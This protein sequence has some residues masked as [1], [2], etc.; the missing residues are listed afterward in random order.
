MA[1]EELNAAE[2]FTPEANEETIKV[3]LNLEVDNHDREVGREYLIDGEPPRWAG[4]QTLHPKP[5]PPV[6]GLQMTAAPFTVTTPEGVQEGRQ[7]D[8]LVLTDSGDL[9]VLPD[10]VVQ[11]T[12]DVK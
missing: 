1:P 4:F 8:W 7:G 9:L 11:K 10:E 12:C 6:K 3:E 2:D 5:Q